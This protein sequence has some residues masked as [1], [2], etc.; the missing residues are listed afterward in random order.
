MSLNGKSVKFQGVALHQDFHGLGVAAPQRAVQRRLAQLK[1][2]G[3][4]AFVPRTIRPART[5]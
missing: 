1:A 4:N 2:L 5:F 3:V